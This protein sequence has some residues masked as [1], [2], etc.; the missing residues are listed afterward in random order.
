MNR[1]V[2]LTAVATSFAIGIYGCSPGLPQQ[3]VEV[4]PPSSPS[5]A[6][7]GDHV[8]HYS[9]EMKAAQSSGEKPV[10]ALLRTGDLVELGDVLPFGRQMVIQPKEEGGSSQ[11]VTGKDEL[12]VL[13]PPHVRE[14]LTRSLVNSGRLIVVERERILEIA[15]ELTAAESEMIEPVTAPKK[16]RLYGVHYILEATFYAP[17]TDG[18][19]Q[20]AQSI[21]RIASRAATVPGPSGQ[22]N[23]DKLSVLLIKA[24]DVETGQIIA[25]VVGANENPALAS[26]DAVRQ[27]LQSFAM[28]KDIRVVSFDAKGNPVLDRGSVSGI[29]VGDRFTASLP[30]GQ[31][32]E[33]EAW[34]VDPLSSVVKVLVGEPKEV[35]IGQ[36]AMLQ[37]K[38]RPA[39]NGSTEERKTEN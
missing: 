10:V 21:P 3:Q 13:L 17:G 28:K 1:Y 12:P 26:Q 22:K 32:A 11:V 36:V 31:R 30:S 35:Q 27:L 9:H 7:Q 24:Y 14:H 25:S 20:T 2:L 5:A 8:F 23:V 37:P 19:V 4:P 15:R 38:P 29:R 39:S 33:L 16:G 34:Q 18:A 6:T